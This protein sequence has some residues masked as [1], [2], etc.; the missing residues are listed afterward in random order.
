MLRTESRGEYMSEFDKVTVVK[1]ANIYFEGG[2]T[3]R[4][5]KFP[6][7]EVKTLGIMLPGAYRFDTGAREIMEILQ[8]EVEV[9]LPGQ[10]AWQRFAAGKSFEVAAQSTFEIK[11]LSVTDYCCSY[12]D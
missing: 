5:I 3:S 10:D 7:G 1:Q 12:L 2:V 11:A 4:T 8:G 6:D 9:L